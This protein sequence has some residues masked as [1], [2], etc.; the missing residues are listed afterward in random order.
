MPLTQIHHNPDVTVVTFQ[1]IID[2]VQSIS[3]PDTFK[4]HFLAGIDFIK[5]RVLLVPEAIVDATRYPSCE[6]A[7]I[8][9]Y[10]QTIRGL[11]AAIGIVALKHSS[12][13]IHDSGQGSTIWH[14][15]SRRIL[16]LR[17]ITAQQRWTIQVLLMVLGRFRRTGPSRYN[18]HV[19][20]EF[21]Q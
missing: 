16:K 8:V 3:W 10:P 18:D 7:M 15:F 19:L 9:D 12:T 13:L 5:T 20:R 11:I 6:G 14:T 2:S 21:L 17:I 1:N 4:I